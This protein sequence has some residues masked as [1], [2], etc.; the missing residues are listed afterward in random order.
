MATGNKCKNAS[1]SSNGKVC[2]NC[3]AP[4]GSARA[5]KLSACA[6]CSLVVYCS[7]ECQR[8]DWKA[9]HKQ[10]CITK[11]DRSP[12]PPSSSSGRTDGTSGASVTGEACSI[13]L[14]RTT[15]SSACTLPCAHVFQ[16]ACVAQL[17]RFG[18]E[19]AC[20]LCRKPLPPGPE[21]LNEEAF[22]RYMVAYQ[23]V[24]RGEASWSTLPASAQHELYAAVASWRT[25]AEQGYPRAQVNLGLMLENGHSGTQNDI[26]AAR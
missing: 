24:L 3:F 23:Q 5:S 4:E 22:R 26:E 13:C 19:Q 11:A 15:D 20:P 9:N 21:K 2:N 12:Q 17:R 6:R 1:S 18:V 10:H 16:S 14:D 8:E 7:R 25:A